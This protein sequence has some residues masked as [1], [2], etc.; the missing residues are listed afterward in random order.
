M[1]V[2]PPSLPVPSLPSAAALAKPTFI[3]DEG[4]IFCCSYQLDIVHIIL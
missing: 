3:V 1:S 4:L 2:P